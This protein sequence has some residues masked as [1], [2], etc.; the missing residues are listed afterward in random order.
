MVSGRKVSV[1]AKRD[2]SP[3]LRLLRRIE[4][5]EA[6][7][8]PSEGDLFALDLARTRLKQYY[9]NLERIAN[10]KKGPDDGLSPEEFERGWQIKKKFVEGAKSLKEHLDYRC[11]SVTWYLNR[12]G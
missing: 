3:H 4:E 8:N 7:E 6:I 11:R 1:N 2:K 10:P 9:R 5:Y 12:Y